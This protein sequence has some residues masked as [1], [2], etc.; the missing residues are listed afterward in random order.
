MRG[1]DQN[2]LEK[3]RQKKKLKSKGRPQNMSEKIKLGSLDN[4]NKKRRKGQNM[5]EKIDFAIIG[6]R[7][8][9]KMRRIFQTNYSLVWKEKL[10]F[11]KT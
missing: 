11:C 2:M 9:Q 1:N 3:I 5:S 8:T 7:Y 10:G 4:K 6:K